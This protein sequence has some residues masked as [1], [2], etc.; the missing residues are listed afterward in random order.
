MTVEESL[1]FI[2]GGFSR[3]VLRHQTKGLE[4][5]ASVQMRDTEAGTGEG[6]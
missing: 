3:T 6:L 4:R 1:P 2:G 5:Q